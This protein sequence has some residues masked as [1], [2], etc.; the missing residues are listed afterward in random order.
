MGRRTGQVPPALQRRSPTTCD[1]LPL[2]SNHKSR[3]TLLQ[4]LQ[5]VLVCLLNIKKEEWPYDTHFYLLM[6]TDYA[7]AAI[8]AKL[9]SSAPPPA[10]ILLSRLDIAQGGSSELLLVYAIPHSLYRLSAFSQF[11]GLRFR[12]G[13]VHMTLTIAIVP[14]AQ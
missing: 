13:G 5:K 7:F 3:T 11:T 4:R 9:L 1:S 12:E 6:R 10:M 14:G 8:P 2:S